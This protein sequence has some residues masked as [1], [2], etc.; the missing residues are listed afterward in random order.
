MSPKPKLGVNIDHIAT[1]RQVRGEEEPNLIEATKVVLRGGADQITVHLREDRRHIQDQD[2]IDLKKKIKIPLNLE[3]AL[4]NQIIKFALKIKPNQITLVPEKRQELTTEGGIDVV[5]NFKKIQKTVQLFQ[6]K[7]IPVYLFIE[8]ATAQ[9]LWSSLS[10][11][12]GIEI[13]T[14]GYAHGKISSAQIAKAAQTAVALGL[15]VHAGHGL[16]KKNIKPLLKIKEIKEYN[17]GHHLISES[18]FLGLEKS[19]REIKEIM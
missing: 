10:G 15:K 1:L 8:P 16:N 11:A 17:I 18:L 7:K 6:D 4:N 13:H 5:K 3:M 19:V 9:I 2:V 14:G 12:E